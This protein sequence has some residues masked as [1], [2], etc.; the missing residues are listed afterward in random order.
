MRKVIL[1]VLFLGSFIDLKAQCSMCRA[2][3][4][5][6][7]DN[8]AAGLNSGIVYLMV[9]PYLFLVVVGYLLFKKHKRDNTLFGKPAV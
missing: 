3:V 1:L 9:F 2:V 7:A 6:N 5:N 4:E 8:I